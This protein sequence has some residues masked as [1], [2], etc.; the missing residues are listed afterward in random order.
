MNRRLLAIGLGL[1]AGFCAYARAAAP[2]TA[3]ARQPTRP[4]LSDDEYKKQADEL[5]AAYLKPREQWPTPNV[6]ESITDF[7]DIGAPDAVKFPDDNKYSEE[8]AALGKQLFFDPRLSASQALACASCHDPDLAWTDGRTV[9]F[10]HDRQAGNRNAPQIMG[11]AFQK[12]Q[13]WDGRAKGLEEQSSFPIAADNEMHATNDQVIERISSQSEYRESFKDVFGDESITM[14]RVGQAIATFERTIIPGRSRFDNF[15]SGKNDHAL[16]DAAIRGLHLFRTAARC[17]NCHNGSNFTDGKF[18]NIGL[19]YY[20]RQYEDFGRYNVTK[21]P[22][23]VGR[24]KTPSL[25]NVAR[26]APYMHNGFFELDGVINLYNAGGPTPRRTAAQ[27]DDPLFPEKDP[28]MQR[29]GLNERDHDD[30]IAFLETLS[31][32]K[33]RVRPPKLPGLS[34]PATRPSTTRPVATGEE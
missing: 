17:I 24:F 3:P 8:K 21:D 30:L 34:A 19:T 6:D 31:E 22:S 28:L 26:T 5:R 16:S 20:G 7:K 32:P 4:L 29:L 12:F 23:D 11:A 25:R 14:Q 9:S 10:G 33:L 13:F 18:H 15:V 27:K 1:A 2:T